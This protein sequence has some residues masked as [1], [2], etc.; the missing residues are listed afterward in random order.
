VCFGRYH[1]QGSSL[2]LDLIDKDLTNI[3]SPAISDMLIKINPKIVSPML[4]KGSLQKYII[5]KWAKFHGAM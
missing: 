3:I 1:L 5:K 2:H 4:Q